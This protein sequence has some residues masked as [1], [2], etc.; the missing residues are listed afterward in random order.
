MYFGQKS[1]FVMSGPRGGAWRGVGSGPVAPS[2]SDEKLLFLEIP[3]QHV[4]TF[5]EQ[6]TALVWSLFLQHLEQ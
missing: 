2:N 5:G 6:C 3:F 4:E 1:S